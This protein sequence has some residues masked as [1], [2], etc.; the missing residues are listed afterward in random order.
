MGCD[1]KFKLHVRDEISTLNGF[2]GE[3][4]FTQAKLGAH[5]LR[6][7]RGLKPRHR[8]FLEENASGKILPRL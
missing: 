4:S 6:A 1:K 2:D 7:V 3:P 5:K 8:G